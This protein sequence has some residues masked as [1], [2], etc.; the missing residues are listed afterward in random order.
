MHERAMVLLRKEQSQNIY[1]YSPLARSFFYMDSEA[2]AKIKRKFDLAYVMAKENIAFT[3]IKEGHGV[4]LGETYKTDMACFAFVDYIARDL[5]DNLS[6]TVQK[7]H[8]FGV[9]MDGSTDCANL[10]EELFMAIYFDYHSSALF[11]N[12][13]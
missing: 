12:V 11:H 3:K 9:Q 5:R 13:F 10:E 7:A 4:D 1:D 2:E 8:F 6:K